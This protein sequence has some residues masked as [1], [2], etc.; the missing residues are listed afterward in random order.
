MEMRQHDIEPLGWEVGHEIHV[1]ALKLA[2]R[3]LLGPA[4]HTI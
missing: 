4:R 1:L 3:E 2:Y